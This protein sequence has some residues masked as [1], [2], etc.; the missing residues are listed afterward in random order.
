MLLSDEFTLSF[1]TL[2]LTKD[3]FY[4]R[5]HLELLHEKYLEENME[6]DKTTDG[7]LFHS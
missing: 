4:L 3:D 1:T 6:M 2:S 7:S 5:C